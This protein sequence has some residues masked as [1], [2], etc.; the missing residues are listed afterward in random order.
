M[1]AQSHGA[2]SC[3]RLCAQ[4]GRLPR[5]LINRSPPCWHSWMLR[6]REEPALGFGNVQ[7]PN[8]NKL[9]SGILSALR[10]QPL[11]CSGSAGSSVR[12]T[13][14][15]RI[16]TA[17]NWARIARPATLGAQRSGLASPKL[18]APADGF[19]GRATSDR[20]S[21]RE[22]RAQRPSE[23]SHGAIRG[24]ERS[25]ARNTVRSHR[26]VEARP[27]E[28]SELV[29]ILALKASFRRAKGQAR[30]VRASRVQ[31][32]ASGEGDHRTCSSGVGGFG[33]GMSPK[34]LSISS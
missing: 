26:W 16:T 19:P 33:R 30:R 4:D 8:G 24:G 17:D 31:L 6:P 23:K 25:P 7:E 5:R 34:I 22:G 29:D 9:T 32:R 12:E 2:I 18:V 15:R 14:E 21:S 3:A 20:N 27:H 11:A 13:P 10:R 1:P 28:P